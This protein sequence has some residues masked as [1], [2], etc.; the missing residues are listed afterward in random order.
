M[1]CFSCG[2][3]VRSDLILASLG[4]ISPLHPDGEGE[5]VRAVLPI[6]GLESSK[7][8]LENAEN[9]LQELIHSLDMNSNQVLL[10]DREA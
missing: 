7:N 10:S 4:D 3:V 1:D 5:G 2:K 8:G 6:S 9:K